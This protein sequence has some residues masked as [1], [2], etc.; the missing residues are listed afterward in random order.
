MDEVLTEK[1]AVPPAT[2]NLSEYLPAYEAT[3]TGKSK[4][5]TRHGAV[6]AFKR[7]LG[8]LDVPPAT[9]DTVLIE[10]ALRAYARSTA[11]AVENEPDQARQQVMNAV[12]IPR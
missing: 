10:K 12:S 8:T 5:A 4:Q 1:I 7:I 11:A 2:V 6:N 3:A 9:V